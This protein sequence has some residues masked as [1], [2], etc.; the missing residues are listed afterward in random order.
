MCMGVLFLCFMK[1]YSSFDFFQLFENVNIILSLGSHTKT[2]ENQIRLKC[3][4]LL[5]PEMMRANWRF[6]PRSRS[7]CIH[8]TK[9]HSSLGVVKK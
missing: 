1:Y 6:Q 2:G 5:I 3:S 7:T 8:L 4:S 9:E